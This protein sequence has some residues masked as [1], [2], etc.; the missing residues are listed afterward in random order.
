[1]S[2]RGRLSTWIGAAA[3]TP[4]GV[5]AAAGTIG[6]D[7]AAVQQ[8]VR[9]LGD[10]AANKATIQEGLS[11]GLSLDKALAPFLPGPL[12]ADVALAISLAEALIALYSALPPD[13]QAIKRTPSKPYKGDG[14]NP[15]TGAPLG[16]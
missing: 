13:W 2:W 8:A 6:Q 11:V 10:L 4:A 1:M 5:S 15:Y 3:S 14:I 7:V 9:F 16:V 12:A